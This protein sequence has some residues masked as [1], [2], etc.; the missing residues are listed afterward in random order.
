MEEHCFRRAHASTSVPEEAVPASSSCIGFDRHDTHSALAA[1]TGDSILV[2]ERP[3]GAGEVNLTSAS[4][5]SHTA[6]D[7]SGF[8]NGGLYRRGR[9]TSSAY[10]T[11]T[12][13][14]TLIPS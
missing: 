5:P 11:T 2:C 3:G 13:F 14:D 1:G 8:Y 10:E 7:G 12:R 9:L 6:F 4:T